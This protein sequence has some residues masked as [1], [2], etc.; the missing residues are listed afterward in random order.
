MFKKIGNL[1]KKE[2]K[3]DIGKLE[4]FY[5]ELEKQGIKVWG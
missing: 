5:K 2:E 4:R 3:I 1:F